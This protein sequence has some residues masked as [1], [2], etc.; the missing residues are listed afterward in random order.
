MQAMR[1]GTK[2]K[3]VLGSAA[4]AAAAAALAPSAALA[5]SSTTPQVIYQSQAPVGGVT[6]K[7]HIFASNLAGQGKALT[8]SGANDVDPAVSPD[9]TKIAFARED[10]PND[11][12]I[13]VMNSDGTGQRL[14]N[15]GPR[16]DRYPTWSPD[17]TRIAFRGYNSA[18]TGG[19][20][21]FVV[22][23]DGSGRD[24]IPGTAGGDQP[25][26]KPD[27]TMIAFTQTQLTGAT[28]PD[29]TPA[30]DDDV[31]VIST[32]G[33][34]PVNL[35]DNDTT[36]DRYPAWSPTDPNT[37]LFRRLDPTQQGREL[38]SVTPA[39]AST[40]RNLSDSNLGAGRAA[41]WAPNG[42]SIAFI[43]YRGGDH[44]GEIYLSALNGTPVQL[45]N[46]DTAED[47]P[48]WANIPV[49]Q[50]A[51]PTGPTTPVGTNGGGG[52]GSG[53]GSAPAGGTNTGTT[54][55]P[56]VTV[57]D[58]SGGGLTLTLSAK[59]LKLGKKKTLKLSAKC[60][61]KCTVTVNGSFKVKVGRKTKKFKVFKAR[62]SV[63]T[64]SKSITVKLPTKGLKALRGYVKKGKTATVTLTA[65]AANP[66]TG[67]FTPTAK[68]KLRVVR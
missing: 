51:V 24:G 54:N 2:S 6:G 53:S 30:T 19:T 27:G 67:E 20:Q 12:N 34:I 21:I 56:V 16:A 44:D 47:E 49:V 15:A 59:K 11:F 9:G 41:G 5:Q 66:T 50:S 43:S 31:A 8:S 61:Q 29:G 39:G 1:L 68:I 40:V 35:T 10:A 23:A 45:T 42:Q 33:G 62:K 3:A 58:P 64:K 26:W 55:K 46:N 65:T 28:N 57:G 25:S 7:W 13:W 32:T 60:S 17:G 38:Y 36:S 18:T 37:I 52:T 48:K 22:A 4:V 14:L 63:S